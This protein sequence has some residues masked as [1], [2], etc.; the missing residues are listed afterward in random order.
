MLYK[1]YCNG[2]DRAGRDALGYR[3]RRDERWRDAQN[4]INVALWAAKGSSRQR[5]TRGLDRKRLDSP[6]TSR[7][8]SFATASAC[9]SNTSTYGRK[10]V[11]P[12]SAAVS[13]L[14]LSS[15]SSKR[16]L[17]TVGTVSGSKESISL[18]RI[19][20]QTLP[21]GTRIEGRSA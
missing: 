8:R 18:A 2:T 17:P 9:L 12:Q 7:A 16:S 21:V 13:P 6:L 19:G 1:Q 20:T 10:L 11:L 14:R 5:E 3:A 15:S 4:S